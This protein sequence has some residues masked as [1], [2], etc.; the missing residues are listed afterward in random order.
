MPRASWYDV[1]YN[2][3]INK[4]EMRKYLAY[5]MKVPVD[6]KRKRREVASS[7]SFASNIIFKVGTQTECANPKN[8][9]VACNAP[10]FT[11]AS[12]RSVYLIEEL[13]IPFLLMACLCH[14]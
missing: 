13:I 2:G 3:K 4:Q 6:A 9:S 12:Y 8:K 14:Y 10:I 7:T 1:K 5:T 11:G